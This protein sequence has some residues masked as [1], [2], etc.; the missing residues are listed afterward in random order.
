MS[1]GFEVGI[2]WGHTTNA[3]VTGPDQGECKALSLKSYVG[4]NIEEKTIG[5]FFFLVG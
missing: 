5:R 4:A 2:L 1:K 3:D